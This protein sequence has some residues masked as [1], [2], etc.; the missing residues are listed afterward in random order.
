MLTPMLLL[1]PSSP[2]SSTAKVP[3]RSLAEIKRY[4]VWEE[5]Y[6]KANDGEG[7]A[8]FVA[9]HTMSGFAWK[10][11]NA[12]SIRLADVRERW[13]AAGKER[14]LSRQAI[15]PSRPLRATG[16]GRPRWILTFR[17]DSVAVTA[18]GEWR[19]SRYLLTDTW[20]RVQGVYRLESSSSSAATLGPR[21]A[22]SSGK[23]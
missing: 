7:L 21:I 5:E 18:D 9:A 6:R 4:Y 20:K 22:E 16:G 12:R 3:F 15:T 17:V 19:K 1:A 11:P 14:T 10:L 8:N 2:R 23:G 13:I